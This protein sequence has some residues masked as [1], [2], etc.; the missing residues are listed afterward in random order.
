MI[1]DR[2]VDIFF[3]DVSLLEDDFVRQSL[4]DDTY[5]IVA[6]DTK[7]NRE[8]LLTPADFSAKNWVLPEEGSKLRRMFDHYAAVNGIEMQGKTFTTNNEAVRFTLSAIADYVM[9]WPARMATFLGSSD[10][11]VTG[12]EV[13]GSAFTFSSAYRAD[14]TKLA[15]I[16]KGVARIAEITSKAPFV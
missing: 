9:L 13:D 4:F 12:H 14:H 6:K 15:D 1:R 5:V 3:G 10:L 2:H 16:Q 7:R 8:T 11:W